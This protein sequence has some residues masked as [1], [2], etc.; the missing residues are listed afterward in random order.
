MFLGINIFIFGAN[1]YK[2]FKKKKKCDALSATSAANLKLYPASDTFYFAKLTGEL[3]VVCK[4]M[5]GGDS[6]EISRSFENVVSYPE[7]L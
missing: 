5:G 4:G 1:V 3:W 2:I 6:L 7:H